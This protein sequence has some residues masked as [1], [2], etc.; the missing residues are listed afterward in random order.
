MDSALVVATSA[1]VVDGAGEGAAETA[2][3]AEGGA[4]DPGAGS[5]PGPGVQSGCKGEGPM[6]LPGY[7]GYMGGRP[8]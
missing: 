7:M 4:A 6:G 1:L 2:D 3:W 8:A 5:G